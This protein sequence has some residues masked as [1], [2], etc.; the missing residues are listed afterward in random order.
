MEAQR[1]RRQWGERAA[2]QIPHKESSVGTNL[3][4]LRPSEEEE[5]QKFITDS[6]FSVCL[7]L[8]IINQIQD[9]QNEIKET[10]ISNSQGC[11]IPE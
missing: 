4:I 11:F 1:G 7:M 8:S 6:T 5:I 9:Q 2:D 10:I 3:R